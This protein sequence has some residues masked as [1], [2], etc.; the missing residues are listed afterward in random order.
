MAAAAIVAIPVGL[1]YNIFLD[2]LVAG[3]TMGAVKG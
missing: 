1:V 2:R 3:F